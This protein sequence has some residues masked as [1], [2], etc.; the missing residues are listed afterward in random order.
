MLLIM[1]NFNF[2]R[3]KQEAGAVPNIPDKMTVPSERSQS[4]IYLARMTLTQTEKRKI[5][6]TE[7]AMFK[8]SSLSTNLSGT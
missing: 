2:D 6:L 8:N 3:S 7:V 5:F 1:T 4:E